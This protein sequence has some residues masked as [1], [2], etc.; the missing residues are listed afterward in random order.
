MVNVN[1]CN[2]EPQVNRISIIV[3]SESW[4]GSQIDNSKLIAKWKGQGINPRGTKKKT[5]SE[6]HVTGICKY[7]KG[8]GKSGKEINHI[9]WRI[10]RTHLIGI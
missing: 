9:V 10:T 4:R 6:E 7:A 3:G 1:K 2:N 8:I 5:K